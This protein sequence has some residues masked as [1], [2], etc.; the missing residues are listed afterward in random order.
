MAPTSTP[1]TASEQARLE[2]LHRYAILDT[3]TDRDFDELVQRAARDCGYPTALLTFMAADRCW[4]K[5]TA[6]VPPAAQ[7]VRELPRDETFCN[8]A[9]RSSGIFSVEDAS[10]DE[11]FRRLRIVDRP[12]GY[13]AY[14]GAQLITPD[15]HSIGTLCLLDTKPHAPTP[16]QLDT[17]RA[18]ATR[19][20]ALLEARQRDLAPAA[21]VTI[22]T[23]V[24]PA[25]PIQIAP[26]TFATDVTRDLV[27]IVDDE[28]L[29]RGVTAAMITRLGCE[30]RM[31]A[32]GQEAL[33]R[34]AALDGRVRLVLTDIHMPV[35]NGVEMARALR[36]RPNA[37]VVVAMSG[38]FTPEV[39]AALAAEGV[40]HLISK[41]FGMAEVEVALKHARSV[42]R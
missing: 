40:A 22:S 1:D 42:A 35:M 36:G 8:Y 18:L 23:T 13:R 11:R 27:L 32:N 37:P 31:A 38:K 12:D 24:R 16:A 17:L 28:E 2:A 4:F 3:G 19:V 21:S 5:A 25:A 14:V 6:G 10:A 33:E 26:P 29:I 30:T 39:R 9:L 41:P 7:H 34:I 15:G 20:M